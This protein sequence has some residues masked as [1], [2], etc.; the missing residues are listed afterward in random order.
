[1]SDLNSVPAGCALYTYSNQ[2]SEAFRR[3]GITDTTRNL[4]VV[5][6]SLKPEIT[7]ES[8]AKH[9]EN[10][11]EATPVP[12]TD[13][14][15][16]SMSDIARIRKIYKISQPSTKSADHQFMN[17]DVG[18]ALEPLILGSIAIRGAT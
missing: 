17:G 14:T 1:M 16:S 12:F 10:S 2:I 15:I 8:V 18:K 5:K 13:E 9:L 7:R 6:L 11:V 3:F 4:L